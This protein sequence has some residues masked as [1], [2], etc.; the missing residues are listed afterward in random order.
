VKNNSKLIS[1]DWLQKK[2][3]NKNKSKNQ[4]NRD[5]FRNNLNKPNQPTWVI[6]KTLSVKQWKNITNEIDLNLCIN[7]TKNKRLFF[8][9]KKNYSILFY[10]FKEN[11][12]FTYETHNLYFCHRYYKE[13]EYSTLFNKIIN[14]SIFNEYIWRINISVM[15]T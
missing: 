12:I 5:K 13:F 2:Y 9:K 1:L 14:N 10:F 3:N 15:C 6:K 4:L 7:L 11:I 8:K